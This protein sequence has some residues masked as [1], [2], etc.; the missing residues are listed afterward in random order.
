MRKNEIVSIIGHSG[1]G[2]STL[3]NMIA[4]LDSQSKVILFLNNKEITGLWT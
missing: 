4:G 2:K 1:C 3:L